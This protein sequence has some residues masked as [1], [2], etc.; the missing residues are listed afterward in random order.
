MG[1]LQKEIEKIGTQIFSKVDAYSDSPL[2]RAFWMR[3]A[4]S[5][6]IARP[7][8]KNAV[9][10]L[11][12]QYPSIPSSGEL[13]SKMATL[14]RTP[15]ASEISPVLSWL[16]SSSVHTPQGFIANNIFK[17]CTHEMA[18]VFIAGETVEDGTRALQRLRK[19]KRGATIDLLGEYAYTNEDCEGYVQRYLQAI[20][21]L[22]ALKLSPV[23]PA[24]RNPYCLSV[25][26]SALCPRA[27]LSDTALAKAEMTKRFTPIVKHAVAQG[28]QL[29]VDAEDDTTNDAIYGT[30]FDIVLSELGKKLVAPGIVV[31]CN[32]KSA[33]ERLR[34]LADAAHLRGSPLAI[35]LVKGAYWEHEM[36]S[37]HEKGTSPPVW[38]T[39]EETDTCYE[40]LSQWLLDRSSLLIPAF[41]SHNVRSLA[42]VIAY[43]SSIKLTPEHYELQVLF[44]MAEPISNALTSL[45]F[46]VREYTPVGDLKNGIGYLVRRLL[47]NSS[48]ESFL[49]MLFLDNKEQAELLKAP[50]QS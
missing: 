17:F 34:A 3:H 18:K 36:V 13:Q 15:V 39:K 16:I 43:A 1:S 11:I 44:G 37:A 19:H 8:T 20:N 48:N 46:F 12:E 35:R 23:H 22:V 14:L 6:L 2:Q 40:E 50:A 41:G 38:K 4:L 29:Y 33:G 30:Y 32:L 45:G 9:F 7:Q 47:E 21:N 10:S 25:K 5:A 31:Q 49:K 24:E 26:L 42:M 27:K 28:V